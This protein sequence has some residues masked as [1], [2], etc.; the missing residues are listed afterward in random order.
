[1]MDLRRAG[2]SCGLPAPRTT[3]RGAC[4]A[5]RS[6]GNTHPRA[7]AC[8]SASRSISSAYSYSSCLMAYSYLFLALI[9]ACRTSISAGF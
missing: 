5:S 3:T 1:M 9:E 8:G 4:P 7:G 6:T 2:D